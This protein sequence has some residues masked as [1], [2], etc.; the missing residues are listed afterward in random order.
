MPEPLGPINGQNRVVE[1][2]VAP[3]GTPGYKKGANP[4]AITGSA[5]QAL[6]TVISGTVA[7]SNLPVTQPVSAAALPLPTGAATD[8]LQGA[9]IEAAP[10]TD[11][12]SSG[13]NGRLQ[14]IAQRVT[15]LIALLPA[16]IGAKAGTG[17]LSVVPATDATFA[18]TQRGITGCILQ[19]VTTVGATAVLVPAVALAGRATMLVQNV[20]ATTIYLGASTVTAGTTA[21]GGVQ[22]L[23]GQS[24]PIDLAA[25]VILYAI[26]SAAGGLVACMEIAA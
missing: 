13:L 19:S 11:T 5:Y 21:T 2:L 3:N 1:G 15:S 14:R 20:G 7:V 18:V 8:A 12:A 17:S 24:V 23:G 25:A 4:Q 6:D 9:L 16:S 22:L 26:S 10:A